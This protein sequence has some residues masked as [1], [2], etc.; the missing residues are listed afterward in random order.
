MIFGPKS[1]GE[2]AV[3]ANN[4]YH[5]Y[6]FNES[7]TEQIKN[8]PIEFKMIK[9]YAACFGTAPVQLFFETPKPKEALFS[10]LSKNMFKFVDRKKLS[11]DKIICI[12][13]TKSHIAYASKD[14]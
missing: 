5:P 7:L 3:N 1:R 14:G 11:K 12:K 4:T 10:P 13:S 2:E 6:Y 9:E 8:D